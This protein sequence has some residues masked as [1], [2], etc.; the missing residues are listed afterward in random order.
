VKIPYRWTLT[1]PNGSFT[2]RIEKVEQNVPI[3]EKLFL[4][5][6]SEPTAQH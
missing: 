2:I 1:R 3:D 6:P 5:P 4:P